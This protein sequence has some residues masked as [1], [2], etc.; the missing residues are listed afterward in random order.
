MA[1]LLIDKPSRIHNL[2]YLLLGYYLSSVATFGLDL[3]FEQKLVFIGSFGSFIG[4]LVYYIK[5]I[6]RAM[7]LYF[8]LSKKN[9]TSPNAPY[10]E[11]CYAV[12]KSDVLFSSF[13]R[14]ERTIIN[15]AFFMAIGLATSYWL[16]NSIGLSNYYPW[17]QIITLVLICA[18]AWEVRILMTT[19]MPLVLYFYNY[20]NLSKNI[21][22][23]EKAIRSKDWIM[24]IKIKENDPEFNDPDYSYKEYIPLFGLCTKCQKPRKGVYC[25][26]CGT[27]IEKN[28][29]CGNRLVESIDDTYPKF[30][31]YCGKPTAK[32]DDLR[33]N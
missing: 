18:G 13:L 5:P 27:K 26:E 3:S 31:I 25:I 15:G 22:Q 14:E 12:Y 24:A 17:L 21:P 7:S 10:D 20:Y 30:C 33:L 6:E 4:A 16:L 19:K 32:A 2:S 8:R 9:C 29:K 28:C 23:L 11:E 1:T